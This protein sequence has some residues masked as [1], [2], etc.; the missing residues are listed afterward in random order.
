MNFSEKL[1]QTLG[2]SIK[3]AANERLLSTVKEAAADKG[4]NISERRNIWNHLLETEDLDVWQHASWI[5][6]QHL[7][8]RETESGLII[9]LDCSNRYLKIIYRKRLQTHGSETELADRRRSPIRY[10]LKA[11]T[12]QS[13]LYDIDVTG[14]EN[15]TKLH[16]FDIDICR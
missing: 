5:P 2:K 16:L 10:R 7:V 8:C 12:L 1:Q 13:T 6:S 3:D 4:R 14:Y 11:F 15:G 9:I